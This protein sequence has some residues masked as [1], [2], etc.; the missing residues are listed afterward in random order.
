MTNWWIVLGIVVLALLGFAF[1]RSRRSG[2]GSSNIET[3]S[4][5]PS[6]NYPQEREDNRVSQMSEEDRAWEAASLQKNR[7][8]QIQNPSSSAAPK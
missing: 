3:N 4:A 7:D 6:R 8:A 1:V 5:A 2:S